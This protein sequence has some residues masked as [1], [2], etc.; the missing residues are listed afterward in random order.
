MNLNLFKL[1]LLV[2]VFSSQAFALEP[3]LRDFHSVRAAGMGDVRYTTGLFEENLYANPARSTDN[4]ES[5]FQFPQI[6]LEANSASLSAFNTLTKSGKNGLAAFKDNIGQPLSARFQMVFPA[7]YSRHF[8]TDDWAFGL[9]MTVAAQTISEVSQSNTIDPTAFIAAGPVINLSRRLLDEDRL[10]IGINIRTELRANSR[11]NFNIQQFLSGQQIS[12][13]IKGGSGLGTDFDLGST[14]K[15]HWGLGGFKYETALAINNILDGQYKNIS[16]PFSSWG[17]NPFQS[18]RSYNF[19]ISATH[20]KVSVFESVVT[21]IEFTD[22]GNNVNGSIF[23]T[24]HIGS[25]AKWK[26]LLARLGISQGYWAAGFGIDVGFFRLNFA[27]YAEEL[28]LNPGV[29]ED[30]RYA[31]QLGFE[32]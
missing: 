25:E 10:S 18:H 30:R 20:D 15:P 26:V 9:G 7:Y 8:I 11:S 1:S 24:I 14:F 5:K 16:R 17:G 19:G 4:P 12:D 28:G 29:I 22:I 6:S 31:A 2:L 3:I 27:S 23:R 21:A 32:I 13:V